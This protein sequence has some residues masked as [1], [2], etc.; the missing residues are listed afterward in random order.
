MEFATKMTLLPLAKWADKKER[1]AAAAAAAV[2]RLL[3][4]VLLLLLFPL[5]VLTTRLMSNKEKRQL[6]VKT[7]Y[8]RVKTYY[9][10]K[11]FDVFTRE[12]FFFFK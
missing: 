1:H 3:S 7:Y 6:K 4:P 12:M 2:L 11:I 8:F 10:E 9:F 5:S